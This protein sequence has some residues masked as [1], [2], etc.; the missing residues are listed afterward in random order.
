MKTVWRILAVILAVGLAACSSDKPRPSTTP[1]EAP[2]PKPPPPRPAPPPAVSP[3]RLSGLNSDEVR[4]LFG[5]PT[6]ETTRAMGKIWRYRRGECALSLVFYP[7]VETEIERVL[8]YELEKGK[9]AAACIKRL[10]DNGGRN[11]K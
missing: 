3:E 9:D 7:E 5:P 6:S 11:G 2:P 10:R 4:A 1:I 8:S